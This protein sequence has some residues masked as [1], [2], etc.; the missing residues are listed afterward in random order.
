LHSDR[1]STRD[2]KPDPNG[3]FNGS[4][5]TDVNAEAALPVSAGSF[6]VNGE[7]IAV[8]TSTDSVNDVIGA[9][10]AS[11]AGVGAELVDNSYL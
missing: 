2:W 1:V 9:I 8:D 7:F 4:L 6:T 10:N 5:G 3:T 11:G